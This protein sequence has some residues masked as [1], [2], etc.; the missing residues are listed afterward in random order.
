[1]ASKKKTF[2]SDF[3]NTRTADAIGILGMTRVLFVS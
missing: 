2:F 1:M 3:R